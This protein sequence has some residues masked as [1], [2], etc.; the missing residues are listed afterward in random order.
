[1]NMSGKTLDCFVQVKG[2]YNNIQILSKRVNLAD[3][4]LNSLTVT[5]GNP[6][7]DLVKPLE[8]PLLLS[9]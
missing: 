3:L 1:M 9:E 8:N 2:Y 7:V 5:I 4:L 6:A